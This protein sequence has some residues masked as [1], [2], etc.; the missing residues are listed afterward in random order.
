MAELSPDAESIRKNQNEYQARYDA[1]VKQGLKLD[2]TRGKPANEQLDLAN[3]LANALAAGDF[4]AADGTDVRNY[5]GL[6]GLP[7]VKAIFADLMDA[8]PEQVI[9]GGN[10]SL[11]L[12]H[13]TLVRAYLFGVPGGKG[14][15][16]KESPKF[17]CPAPGYDRHFA[18]CEHLGIEMITIE[19]G[20]DGPDMDKVEALVSSDPS[21]K[22]IWCVP[23]YSNPTG[24]TYSDAVVDRLVSMKTAAPD[25]RIMWDNAYAVHDLYDTTDPLKNILRAAAEAGNAD[26]PLVFASTSKISLAGAGI[27]AMAASSTNIADTKSH[28]GFQ[29]IG[30]DKVNQLRHVRFFQDAGGVRAHM[31]KHA[32]LI[33]PKFEAVD[34]ILQRELGGLGIAAW[35]HPR[36]GYFVSLDTLD[37]LASQVVK[38]AADAGVKLTPAGATYPYQKDGRDRNIRL[39]PTLPP[40]AQVEIAMEVVAVCVLL[41]TAKKLG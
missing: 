4:K 16:S 22:G 26:R 2:M 32:E 15:W 36:G 17:L 5:G 27:A 31:R 41:A 20:E 28:L 10:S 38:L 37:G 9:I 13:D 34:R 12:M 30:P 1:F 40:R 24:A 6:D 7:E 39:A 3:G 21:I 11:T 14:P 35:T 33:R 25:F 8:T 18:I 29:T 23:K 19:L